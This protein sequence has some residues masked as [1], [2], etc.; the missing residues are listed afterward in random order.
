MNS[1]DQIRA[2]LQRAARSIGAPD[3]VDPAVERPRDQSHGDWATNLPMVLARALKAKPREVAERLRETMSL[4]GAGQADGIAE[5]LRDLARL[6][7]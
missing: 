4:A 7:F 2:E 6:G 1:A 5:A 3:D